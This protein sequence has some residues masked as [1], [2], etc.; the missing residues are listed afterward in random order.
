MMMSQTH[1]QILTGSFRDPAGFLFIE[2]GI[3]YRQINQV[4]FDD[5]FK[6]MESGLYQDLIQAELLIPHEEITQYQ[7][8]S[9]PLHL[10]IKPQKVNF[11]SYP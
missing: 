2:D 5:Y 10:I 3:L 4:G 11:I 8:D 1:K 7:P 6:L 9:L